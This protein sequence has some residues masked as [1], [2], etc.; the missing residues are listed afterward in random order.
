M[1]S[2]GLDTTHLK[3]RGL[4]LQWVLKRPRSWCPCKSTNT[5]HPFFTLNHVIEIQQLHDM[6]YT[7]DHTCQFVSNMKAIFGDR[8]TKHMSKDKRKMHHWCL[9]RCWLFLGAITWNLIAFGFHSI[10]TFTATHSKFTQFTFHFYKCFCK[11]R[12]AKKSIVKRVSK[13]QRAT[14]SMKSVKVLFEHCCCLAFF[15]K[16]FIFTS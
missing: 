15:F 6:L 7:H 9:Y 12:H 2:L 4:K 13:G 5:F 10:P 1:F 11:S 8:M 16:R 3:L 14:T